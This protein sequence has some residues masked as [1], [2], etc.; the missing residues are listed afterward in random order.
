MKAS[1]PCRTP[2]SKTIGTRPPTRSTTSGSAA[3]VGTDWS[4]WR[5]PWLDT[6]TPST[7]ASRARVASSGCTMPLRMIGSVV[8]SRAL[9]R[10]SQV[11]AGVEN[12]SR[13]VSTAA[14]GSG[15]RRLSRSPAPVS[16]AP[17]RAI[18][19]PAAIAFGVSFTGGGASAAVAEPVEAPLKRAPAPATSSWNTGSLVYCAIPIPRVNG[20]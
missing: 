6:H 2:E 14:R 12:T 4:I 8:H 3:S 15:E 10:S 5:P 13:K 1:A 20:R 9:A 19:T 16:G 18:L 17:L 11:S 7:P